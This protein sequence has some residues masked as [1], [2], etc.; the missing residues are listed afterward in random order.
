[1]PGGG[2]GIIL[3]V[4][5]PYSM[6]SLRRLGVVGIKGP[7]SY[8]RDPRRKFVR[9]IMEDGRDRVMTYGRYLMTVEGGYWIPGHLDIHHVDG[10]PGNDNLGNLALLGH[11]EHAR[12]HRGP[13]PLVSSVCPECGAGVVREE[14]VVRRMRKCGRTGPFCSRVCAGRHNQRH[15][16]TFHGGRTKAYS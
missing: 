16:V 3:T 4:R 5:L 8:E 14:R 12:G 13:A 7:F 11:A 15:Q 10:D 2:I 1:M 6:T 9:L